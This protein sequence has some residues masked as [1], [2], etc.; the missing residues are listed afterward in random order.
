VEAI[1]QDVTGELQRAHIM[2]HGESPTEAM[3]R[4]AQWV[5]DKKA[6]NE[7]SNAVFAAYPL[8][9][10]FMFTYWYLISFSAIGSPFGHARHI[11]IKTLYKEKAKTLIVHS[12]KS[13]MPKWLHSK[14]PHTHRA[15]Q[16]SAEQGELLMNLLA[17]E[18]DKA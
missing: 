12:V 1:K 4:F 15:D 17:W 10:D 11:D 8:G 18:V 16:D 2:E 6:E 13:R 5:E 14:L 7:T 9:F 3:T